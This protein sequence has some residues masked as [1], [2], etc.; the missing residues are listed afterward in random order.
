M[1]KKVYLVIEDSCW[2]DD[3]IIG[4]SIYEKK[5]DAEKE[6]KKLIEMAKKDMKELTTDYTIE[7]SKDLFSI[8]ETGYYS[9]Y[10]CDISLQEKE[11]K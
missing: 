10:H 6:F 7:Q 11:I 1:N 4:S 2:D 8:F 3:T 9:V 5:E